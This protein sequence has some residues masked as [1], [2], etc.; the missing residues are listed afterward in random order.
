MELSALATRRPGVSASEA[1]MFRLHEVPSPRPPVSRR[2]HTGAFPMRHMALVL[3]AAALV[4]G[5]ANLSAQ[6]PNFAG[7][8]TRIVDRERPGDGRWWCARCD[9]HRARLPR[10]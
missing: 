6:T 7:T 1:M 10:R 3:A 4:V 8:W 2:L 5:A 9:D